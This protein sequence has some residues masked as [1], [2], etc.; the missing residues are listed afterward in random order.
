MTNVFTAAEKMM[1]LSEDDWLR[2]AN[3]L[4]GWTRFL[5][6]APLLVFAIWSRVWIGWW[7]LAAVAA[8]LVWIWVNPRAFPKPHDYGSWMSRAVLGERIFLAKDDYD[9]PQHHLRMAHL[10]T[11]LALAG[12][13]PLIWGLI[14]LDPWAAVLGLALAILAKA[15]F[16]DR[17]VWLHADLTGSVPGTPQPQPVM[18]QRKAG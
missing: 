3:P 6:G 1:A 2:H 14:V 18:P 11:A 10:T 12:V 9:I 4:S 7:A 5:T 13:I 16:C 17:M 8:A 15:W